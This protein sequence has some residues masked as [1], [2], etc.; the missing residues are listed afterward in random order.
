MGLW[1]ERRFIAKAVFVGLLSA[2]LVSLLITPKYESTTR[3]MP[4]EK[5]GI[6]GLGALLAATGLAGG[7]SDDKAGSMVG[8]LVSDA[9][10]IKSS[11][12][13]WV[14]VLKST[15]VRDTLIN[16]FD[17]RKVYRVRHIQDARE[18]LAEH[19]EIDE[20]RKSGIISIT[21]NDR[22]PQRA[23]ALAKAYP[24][25]LDRLTSKL[26]TSAEHKE[27]VFLEDRLKQVK[28]DLDAAAKE[29]SD[30]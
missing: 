29:L 27:R 20:D 16:E 4:P 17:L 25:N 1:R 7:G 10:G 22:S 14:G 8:G 15:T 11:G 5:Q 19:T 12:A 23:M 30:F 6:G 2:A 18:A 21:V 26:N 24:E 9:M 28:Q 13:L 3:I